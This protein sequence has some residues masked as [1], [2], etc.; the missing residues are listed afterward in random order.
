MLPGQEFID[1]AADDGVRPRPPPTETRKPSSPASFFTASRPMSCTSMAARSLTAPFTAILNLRG[2]W[3]NSGWKV[4]HWRMISHQGRGSTSSSRGDAGELVGGGVADAAAAGLNRVHLHGGQLGEDFRHVFQL[5]PV[6]L[7]VLPGAD[8]GVA[9]VVVAG[10]LRQ[11]AQLAR[12]EQAIGNGDAQHR[13]IALDI[14]TVLQAQRAELLTGQFTRQVTAGLVAELLDAV[15]DDPLVV[16]VVYVHEY[17]CCQAMRLTALTSAHGYAL[18]AEWAHHTSS[19]LCV[20]VMFEYMVRTKRLSR[21][22]SITASQ[23]RLS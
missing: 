3:A 8:V 7:H 23:R 2:R 16:L 10:D 13:G 5:R 15:L 14:E 12:G 20:K 17:S 11:L 1:E 9:L 6:E 18:H 21:Q 4:D 22:A 19:Y